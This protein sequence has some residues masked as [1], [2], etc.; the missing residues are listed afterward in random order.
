M[1]YIIEIVLYLFFYKIPCHNRSSPYTI[2][3]TNATIS[4]SLKYPLCVIQYLS[5]SRL[6]FRILL[7]LSIAFQALKYPTITREKKQGKQKHYN[8]CQGSKINKEHLVQ[9]FQPP[10]QK[11]TLGPYYIC[12]SIQCARV[13]YHQEHLGNPS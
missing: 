4:S 5:S 13:V 9:Y 3:I 7:W 11:Y 12:T 8:N 10:S 2:P 6:D 1:Y